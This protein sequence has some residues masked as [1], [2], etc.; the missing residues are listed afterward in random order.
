MHGVQCAVTQA[1]VYGELFNGHSFR[2]GTANSA[3]QAG[4]PETMIKILGLW[5]NSAYQG[6]IRPSVPTLAAISSRM[7]SAPK[8]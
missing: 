1:G 6:Y 2:I 3:N 4:I 7:V 8:V 5:Q